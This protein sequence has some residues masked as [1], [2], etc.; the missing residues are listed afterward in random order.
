[1]SLLPEKGWTGNVKDVQD[2]GMFSALI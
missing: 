1:V 2:I